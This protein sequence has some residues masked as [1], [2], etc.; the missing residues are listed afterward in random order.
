MTRFL[1]QDSNH[2]QRK[3]IVVN[4]SEAPHNQLLK[5]VPSDSVG[6]PIIGDSPIEELAARLQP[7]TTTPEANV[8][9]TLE[10]KL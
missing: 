4:R 1:L 6:S 9:W 8:A 5:L 10:S 3:I 7:S 2:P